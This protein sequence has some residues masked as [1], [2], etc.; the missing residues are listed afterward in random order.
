MPLESR[1]PRSSFPSPI[2]ADRRGLNPPWPPATFNSKPQFPTEAAHCFSLGLPPQLACSS[3]ADP[4]RKRNR[5]S[6]FA[7]KLLRALVN[8]RADQADLIF[9]QRPDIELVLGGH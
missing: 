9:R 6:L 3:G 8:P 5:P 4:L 2:L 7:P 1:A